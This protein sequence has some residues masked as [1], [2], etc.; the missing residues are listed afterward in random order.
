MGNCVDCTQKNTGGNKK[1]DQ[2][3]GLAGNQKPSRDVVK[4]IAG[5][6]IGKEMFILSNDGRFKDKYSMGVML[7][8]GAFGEV[9]KC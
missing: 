8:E 6:E 5:L 2:Y 1:K 3:G 7:G 9:R 4:N